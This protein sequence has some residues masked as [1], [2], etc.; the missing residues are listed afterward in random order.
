MRLIP[1]LRKIHLPPK[2]LA[3]LMPVL[4]QRRNHNMRRPVLAELNN[5]LRQV[6]LNRMNPRRF[7][8][9]VQLNLLSRH[10]F[11]LDDLSRALRAGPARLRQL[12]NN[13]PRL[14]RIA[15]PMHHPARTRA[16]RLKLLQIEIQVLHRVLTN[17]L[18]RLAQIL[19]VRHLRDHTRPLGLNHIRRM[20]NIFPQ[21]HIPQRRLRRHRKGRRRP[22][23]QS[24]P[25][26][27][28]TPQEI[29]E[30]K[31][32]CPIFATV[33]LS[34]RWAFAKRTAPADVG[35]CEI[36]QVNLTGPTLP[37]QPESPPDAPSA[38]PSSVDAAPPEYASNSCYRK[39][40]KPQPSSAKPQ[41]S[42]PPASPLTH[43]RSSPQTCR[44]TR[45]TAPPPAT[46]PDR[47]PAPPSAIA[48]AH[49][50]APDSVIHDN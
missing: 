28:S 30:E 27:R 10:R 50:P 1:Q 4:M 19:P 39:P 22:R 35:R 6:R 34:L 43:P 5:Q 47:F 17:L 18:P 48:P 44:Q 3:N 2:D 12:N 31:S 15:S 14:F 23:I 26:H 8:R 38:L 41:P 29:V 33:L 46:P 45:S 36:V 49:H 11:D 20:T 24:S 9:G 42:Y 13:P 37:A 32:G 7:Q 16:V 40:Y 25:T 21:L